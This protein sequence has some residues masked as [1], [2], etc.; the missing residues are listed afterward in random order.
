MIF[1]IVSVVIGGGWV[2]GFVLGIV[3]RSIGGIS[4]IK[5]TTRFS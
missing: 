3:G 1:S 4:Q 5:L 2:V